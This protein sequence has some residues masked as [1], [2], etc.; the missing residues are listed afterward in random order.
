MT[1]ERLLHMSIEVLHLPK[2]F[3]PPKKTNF[4]LLPCTGIHRCTPI[5]AQCIATRMRRFVNLLA[6]ASTTAAARGINQSC[7][8]SY[9]GNGKSSKTKASDVNAA[10][11]RVYDKAAVWAY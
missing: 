2:K 3:I 10:C 11:I 8:V 7:S 4:W 5:L 6:I 1:S 9:G